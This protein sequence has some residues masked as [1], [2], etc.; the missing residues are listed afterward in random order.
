MSAELLLESL[1]R[2]T[3][4][5]TVGLLVVLS[6]RL[7]WRHLFGARASL[8]LWWSLP[9]ALLL[10]AMP[11]PRQ[12]L[13]EDVYLATAATGQPGVSSAQLPASDAIAAATPAAPLNLPINHIAANQPASFDL[14]SILPAILIAAWLLGATVLALMLLRRQRRF[15]HALGHLQPIAGRLY[16]GSDTLPSPVLIGLL[17]PRIVIPADFEQR[18]SPEQRRLVLAHEDW[19]LRRLDLWVGLATCV[20]R[21]LFWFHPLLPLALRRFRLDQELAC[22]QAV[23]TQQPHRRG[24][25]ARALLDSQLAASGL[26]VGCFWQSSQPLKTR[27]VMI[28]KPLPAALRARFGVALGLFTACSAA[29]LAWAAQPAAEAAPAT[30]S[31]QPA[32]PPA[33]PNS[34]MAAAPVLA[35]VT[36][37]ASAETRAVIAPAAPVSSSPEASA[38]P[39][40]KPVTKPATLQPAPLP[41]ALAPAAISRAGLPAAASL[42]L[43]AAE[44]APRVTADNTISPPALINQERPRYPNLYRHFRSQNLQDVDV[45]IRFTVSTDGKTENLTVVDSTDSRFELSALRAVEKWRFEPATRQGQ[46]VPYQTEVVVKFS[47]HEQ[48]DLHDG[49]NPVGPEIRRPYRAPPSADRYQR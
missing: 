30:P 18:F 7:P 39:R 17:S 49:I 4:A 31:V 38:A 22:D 6:L 35:P 9:L 25:Y 16:R 44:P 24:D 41:P 13:L 37:V 45:K 2:Y 3:A 48:M 14:S 34:A 32:I 43:A 19:H 40:A 26:P 33:T 11:A 15:E 1:L 12:S 21:C 23:L 5:L 29:S 42:V 8:W 47:V 28:S 10:A 20:L 46:P 36:P 27:I